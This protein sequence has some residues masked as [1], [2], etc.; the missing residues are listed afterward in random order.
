MRVIKDT[1]TNVKTHS[2][3]WIILNGFFSG[4]NYRY[5][6]NVD[7]ETLTVHLFTV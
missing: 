5:I 6:Y 4:M 2:D 7:T 1:Y 3:I